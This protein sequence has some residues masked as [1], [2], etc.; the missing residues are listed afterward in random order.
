MSESP[1]PS[2]QSTA[3]LPCLAGSPSGPFLCPGS[4]RANFLPSSGAAEGS[5]LANSYSSFKSSAQMFG[6]NFISSP[7]T[8]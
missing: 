3:P 6:R 7:Q 2:E 4:F 1:D 8:P 5:G